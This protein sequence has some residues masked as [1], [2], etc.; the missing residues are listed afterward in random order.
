MVCEQASKI[1]PWQT[2]PLWRLGE[3]TNRALC[4][5]Y[6]HFKLKLTVFL[7][8]D[9]KK[10][11]IQFILFINDW[12]FCDAITV[13]F[14]EKSV[15]YQSGSS[16]TY[17]NCCEPPSKALL[18]TV[19][20]FEK[21]ETMPWRKKKEHLPVR[22]R[23]PQNMISYNLSKKTFLWKIW[24][25]WSILSTVCVVFNPPFNWESLWHSLVKGMIL[26]FLAQYCV[27]LC[28][29]IFLQVE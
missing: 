17:W 18:S 5:C 14:T 2:C 21:Q 22:R 7:I 25:L 6:K 28:I 29:Y 1:L 9:I 12:V 15:I 20:I 16:E 8:T 24:T 27:A 10:M 4:L 3:K 26:G 13:V 11:A 23:L 19:G